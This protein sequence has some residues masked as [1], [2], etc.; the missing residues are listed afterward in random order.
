ML[1][2]V[3]AG[4]RLGF[5]AAG[6]D[7][8]DAFSFAR[9]ERRADRRTGWSDGGATDVFPVS[10][11][12]GKRCGFG[13]LAGAGLA[14][15]VFAGAVLAGTALTGTLLAGAVLVG[16]VIAGAGLAGTVRAGVVLAGIALGGAALARM[17]AGVSTVLSRLI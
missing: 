16:A 10:G 11:A 5:V 17:T 3:V 8:P 15:A 1:G 14:A 7:S 13:A 6:L 2:P 9:G 4:R 12:G